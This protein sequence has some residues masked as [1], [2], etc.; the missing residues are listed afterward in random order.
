MAATQSMHLQ[1]WQQ[2]LANTKILFTAVASWAFMARSIT[3]GQWIALVL[4]TIGV[5][6]GDWRADG[7]FEAPLLGVFIMLFNSCLSAYAG[8]LMERCLKAPE[9]KDLT[10]FATNFHSATYTLLLN[11]LTVILV[12]PAISMSSRL[13]NVA[14]LA[15]LTNE[16]VNGIL[17][18]LLMRRLDGIAKWSGFICAASHEPSCKR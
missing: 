11:S 8:V 9:S 13:P 14:D 2:L 18:S 6:L 1:P 10:I 15:A 3:A 12:S 7:G 5:I 16:A 17:M 4:L